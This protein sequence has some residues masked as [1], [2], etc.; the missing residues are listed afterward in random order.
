[1]SY[2]FCGVHTIALTLYNYV[3]ICAQCQ[4][5]HFMFNCL[6]T[7]RIHI[8]QKIIS[9][10]CIFISSAARALLFSINAFK[11]KL[12]SFLPFSSI[13]FN[14]IRLLCGTPVFTYVD[15]IQRWVAIRNFSFCHFFVY[16]ITGYTFTSL[17]YRFLFLRH[18]API[19][20]HGCSFFLSRR[21]C[22]CCPFINSL[23]KIPRHS[24]LPL[25]GFHLLQYRNRNAEMAAVDI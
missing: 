23:K 11:F 4:R 7:L 24:Y 25:L 5:F 19:R 15:S 6:Q 18:L 13:R 3:T 8:V 20:I 14:N 21:C 2:F 9:Y 16:I 1:M 12:N 10:N 22:R 17:Y